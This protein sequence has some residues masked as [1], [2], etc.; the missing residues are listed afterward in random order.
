MV[1]FHP[2]RDPARQSPHGK[3]NRKHLHG[4]TQCAVDDAGVEVDIRI[5]SSLDEVRIVQGD[6]FQLLCDV[7]QRI[8]DRPTWPAAGRRLP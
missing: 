1:H 3:Q 7:E 4:N 2:V 5:Q 8:V 6:F